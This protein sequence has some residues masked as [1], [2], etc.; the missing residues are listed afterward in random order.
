MDQINLERR[1]IP[2]VTILTQP[3]IGLAGT[4]ALAEIDAELCSVAVPH[5]LGMIP[6]PEVRKKADDAFPAILKAATEWQQ[7]VKSQTNSP[8]YPAERFEIAGTV[9]D[10]NRQLFDKGWSLGLPVIP[11]TTERVG[12]MLK[13][14]SRKPDE[15]IGQ[16]PPRMGSLTIELVAANAVMAGC[17]PEYMP[18]LVVALE[19]LLSPEA[20]WR[21][22]LATTGTSQSVVIVNGPIIS[23]IGLACQ[24][25]A[26]GKGHHANATIGYAIN[27]IAYNVGGSR[28]PSIDKS[29]LGSPG[30]FVCWVF[31]ENEAELPSGWQPLH[32]ERGFAKSDSVV[33]VMVS[34]PPIN[35]LD[36]WSATPEEHLRY[37][38]HV[39]NPLQNAGGPCQPIVMKQNPILAV[40]PEHAQL[41]ASAGWN[42]DDL[43]EALWT[44]A[45]IPLSDLPAGCSHAGQLTDILG[46]ITSKT[47][48]PIIAR[49]EQFLIAIAG[50]DGKHSHYFPPFPGC[51]PVSKPVSE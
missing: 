45:R 41:L 25:G 7:P 51:F 37:W 13:G 21:S 47:M 26:A 50:G 14:T 40:G 2:S 20:D 8:V 9:E 39:I 28:P 10:V 22:A 1:G 15:V 36:H 42:K 48:L 35:N 44:Q 6:A 30:D 33:T 17:K 19:A 18:L 11:P 49:A 46:P 23:R 12:G 38:S 43:K 4:I 31:G 27:L 5:P 34:Y 16:V 24:Q 3:F 29:T 32:V